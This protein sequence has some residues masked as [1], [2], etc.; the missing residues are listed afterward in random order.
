MSRERKRFLDLR[1]RVLDVVDQ[2][3]GAGEP[4]KSYDGDMS[5][6]YFI[7]YDGEEKYKVELHCYLIGPSRHYSWSGKTLN[8]AL[9]KAEKDINKWIAEANEL[10]ADG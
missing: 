3:R 1:K 10:Y 2:L 6:E 9:N 7:G 8:A 5:V 4:G